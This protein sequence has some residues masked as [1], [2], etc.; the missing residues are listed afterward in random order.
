[1]GVF[2]DFLKF[3]ER[4]DDLF[5]ILI[6]QA[7]LFFDVLELPACVNKEN[8][9]IPL[10]LRLIPGFPALV[11]NENCRRYAGTVE[12]LSWKPGNRLKDILFDESFSD[13]AF[14]P[15]TEQNSMRN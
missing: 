14:R 2:F 15:A 13:N 3:T 8:L 1:V 5:D 4:R 10:A 6:P 9:F 11:E 7:V 12:K